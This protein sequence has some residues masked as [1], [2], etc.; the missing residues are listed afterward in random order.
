VFMQLIYVGS[1][2]GDNGARTLA[3]VLEANYTLT[4]LKL[5][6]TE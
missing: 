3:T 2:I 1:G 5:P 4:E 6:S